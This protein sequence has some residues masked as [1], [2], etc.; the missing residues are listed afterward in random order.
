MSDRPERNEILKLLLEFG[1]DVHQRGLNGWLALHCVAQKDDPEAIEL[2]LRY[3]A[4]VN[5]RTNVDDYETA[6]EESERGGKKKAVEAL[7]KAAQKK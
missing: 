4:D 1:A 7:K 6:L 3:G 5:A 2:V